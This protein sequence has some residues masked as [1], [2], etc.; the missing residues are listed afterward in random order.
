MEA[1]PSPEAVSVEAPDAGRP[2]AATGETVVPGG[3]EASK[4]EDAALRSAAEALESL[5]ILAETIDCPECGEPQQPDALICSVCGHRLALE[6]RVGAAPPDRVPTVEEDQLLDELQR[7]IVGEDKAPPPPLEPEVSRAVIAGKRS[8]LVF[9]S[10]VPGVSKRAADAVC[11]FFQDL[12]QVEHADVVQIAAIPGV[13]PAEARLVK[14]AV[15]RFFTPEKHHDEIEPSRAPPTHDIEPTLPSPVS[16]PAQPTGRRLSGFEGRRGLVNGQGMVNGRG[17]VNGLVNGTGFVNGVAIA[18]FR[19]P[20]QSLMPRYIAIGASLLMLF[21]ATAFYLAPGTPPGIVINGEFDDWAAVP[22]YLGGT[23]SANPNVQISRTRV[24]SDN[25]SVF[26]LVG[27]EAQEIFSAADWETMYAFLDV[28]GDETTGYDM[29]DMGAD[30]AVRVSGS[31]LGSGSG[32]EIGESRLLRYDGAG[33]ARDDWSGFVAAL[34]VDASI[35]TSQKDRME[36]SVP[37]DA[38]EGL[39]EELMRVRFASDDNAGETSHT[40]VPIGKDSGALLIEQSP[41]TTTLSGGRQPFLT[42]TFRSLGD[43]EIHVEGVQLVMRGGAVFTPDPI[44]PFVVPAGLSTVRT[45]SVDSIGLPAETLVTAIVTDVTIDPPE[46][47]FAIVGPEARAYVTERPAEKVIDG[48]FEDWSSPQV[49]MDPGPSP[50]SRRSLNILSRDGN[51]SGNRMSFYA[52]LG[53]DALEGGLTPHKPVRPPPEAPGGGPQSPPSGPPPPLVGQDYVRFFVDTDARTPS[54][55]D[56]DGV[57]ADRML[58]VRGRAGR[59]LNASVYQFDG[60]KWVW[61]SA[62]ERGIGGDEI[63]VGVSLLGTLFNGTQFVA[64]TADWAGVAD[65]ASSTGTRGGAGGGARSSSGPPV[66]MDISGNGAFWFRDTN[67]ASETACTHNKVASSTK[68]SGVA[69][70]IT[71]SMTETACW[72]VDATTSQTIVAGDWETLLDLSNTGGADYDVRIEIWNKNTD[73]VDETIQM[74]L[75]ATSFGDDIQCLATSVAQKT[76][77]SNQVVRLLL[78]HSFGSGTIT[79]EYDDS[80]STGDSRTTLPIPEFSEVAPAAL[81]VV[82]LL[83]AVRARRRRQASAR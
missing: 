50:I 67:H 80:D 63:E 52:R 59:A 15:V 19:L 14:V 30:Y 28:D 31:D 79:I 55:F 29:G 56:I 82:V 38:L 70:T 66:V 44:L 13:A 71:L 46:V 64:V 48:L 1:E 62:L 16:P 8:M 77:N 21:A 81:A 25:S 7:A 37:R 34:S 6:D 5:G 76:L 41:E 43:A 69:K 22:E 39:S 9:L 57:S 18:E 36:V 60:V 40:L 75:D 65:R 83:L 32:P 20:R 23:P 53:G 47:P 4:E 42:L 72:Y 45:I 54:G 74:C 51:V 17:R 10:R 33:R 49:D 3:T 11:G 12:E 61:E 35:G 68:G 24:A 2:G 26:L 78:A 58:E 73:S 27:V